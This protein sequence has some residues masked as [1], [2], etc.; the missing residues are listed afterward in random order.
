MK[1]ITGSTKK[2]LK[3]KIIDLKN[4]KKTDI[5]DKPLCLTLGNFDGVHEGHARL[6]ECAIEEGRA[7]GIKAAVWTFDEH[8]M[9]TLD[10]RK[11]ISY[12]TTPE[13]KNDL[14][15]EKGLDYAIYEDFDR[16]KDFSP[17]RFIDEIL[18]DAFDCKA[19]VCGFNFKFGKNGQG[20]PEF[21]KRYMEERGRSVIIVPPVYKLNKIVSSTAVRFFVENGCME[22]ASELLGRPFSIKFPVLH[23][24]K[25]G[26]SIGIP[27]INQSFPEDHIKPK[28]GIYACTCFIGDDIFLGVS[29]VGYR[30]TVNCDEQKIN[31]ET[32]IINYNGWL[33]GKKIRVCFYKRLRDEKRFESL[34]DLKNAVERDIASTIDYFSKM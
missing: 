27:T 8:P 31:C 5:T 20:S 16:V 11:R 22:E 26:R 25:L 30:P 33:Y 14:F 23:G 15:A 7:L 32:H 2:V 18:I 9:N 19:V 6:I 12:L 28:N 34:D 24:K 17:E 3:M 4:G 21:L 1:C 10:G 29:N 13:E